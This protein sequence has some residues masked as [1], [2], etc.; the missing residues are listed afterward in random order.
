MKRDPLPAHVLAT[1][2]IP[3]V[4][5]DMA[6]ELGLTPDQKS[7]AIITAD[8]DDVTYTALD[9]ATKKADCKVVYA[10][11]STPALPTPTP[12]WPARSSASWPLPTPLRPRPVWKPAWT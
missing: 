7:L 3:N 8:C 4:A 2:L 6:K 12:R 10:R 5:P 1:R 11:A 9:E